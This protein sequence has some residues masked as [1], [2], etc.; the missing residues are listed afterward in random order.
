MHREMHDEIFASG[1][2]TPIAITHHPH[3]RPENDTASSQE[4]L[5]EGAI[6]TYREFKFS[7]GTKS[8]PSQMGRA[9]ILR[10]GQ[11]YELE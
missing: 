2:T 4:R 7:P 6:D 8:V 5:I 10:S 1:W 3:P 9:G 11:Q